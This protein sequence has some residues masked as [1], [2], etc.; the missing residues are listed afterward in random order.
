MLCV[1]RAIRMIITGA[2]SDVIIGGAYSTW[3]MGKLFCWFFSRNVDVDQYCRHYDENFPVM[4]HEYFIRMNIGDSRNKQ[5]NELPLASRWWMSS[6]WPGR[7]FPFR[8]LRLAHAN[9]FEIDFSGPEARL[10]VTPS[11]RRTTLDFDR[12]LNLPRQTR[13]TTEGERER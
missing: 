3:I 5:L 7:H 13:K 4:V 12:V 10:T 11:F 2:N 9:A 8:R 1:S 6:R